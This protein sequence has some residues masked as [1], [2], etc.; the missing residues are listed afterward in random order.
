[1][2][3][4]LRGTVDRITSDSLVIDINGVGYRAY[5]S[6]NT[7]MEVVMGETAKIYTHTYVR[8]DTLALYGFLGEDELRMFEL[9]LSVSGVGPKASL[10][11]VSSIPPSSFSLA[12]LTEDADKLTKAQGI[13]K[14]GAQRIILELKDKL[15]K[16]QAASGFL[17]ETIARSK[18]PGISDIYEEAVSALMMLGYSGQDAQKSV[19][20]VMEEGKSVEE[21][22]REALKM[23]G[24]NSK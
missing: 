22:I 6:T 8:E 4:H 23:K 20:L 16:E 7:L 12:V 18:E 14:K 2:I 24:K 21:V 13:G 11:L 3:A 1:M 10:S 19:S 17:P 15:K 5:T 9:L